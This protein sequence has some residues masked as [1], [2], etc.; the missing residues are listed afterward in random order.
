MG[1][2]CEAHC[3]NE[4]KDLRALDALYMM[5]A[6]YFRAACTL[7]NDQKVFE[8]NLPPVYLQHRG[9]IQPAPCCSL[10]YV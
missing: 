5:V 6:D 4:T 2:R 10:P 3:L 9:M 8:T 1:I 7:D